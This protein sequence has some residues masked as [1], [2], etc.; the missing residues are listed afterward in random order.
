MKGCDMWWAVGLGIGAAMGGPVGAGIGAVIGGAISECLSGNGNEMDALM[1]A[2]S[3]FLGRFASETGTLGQAEREFIAD[4]CDQISTDRTTAREEIID[5]LPEW[6]ANDELFNGAI[7]AARE[8]E[9]L[10]SQLLSFVWQMASR[11][12]V[13]EANETAWINS[14]SASMGASSE[15]LLVSMIPYQRAEI[16]DEAVAGAREALGVTTT[17]TQHEIKQKYKEL[18][19]KYHPDTHST[20]NETLKELTAVK[21]AQV[22][23][24]YDTLRS[25]SRANFWAVRIESRELFEPDSRSL[26]RCYFCHQKCRLPEPANFENS[27]CPKCRALLL[28]ERELAGAI[29]SNV[30]PPEEKPQPEPKQPEAKP[31]PKQSERSRPAAPPDGQITGDY[32]ASL[33]GCFSRLPRLRCPGSAAGKVANGHRDIRARGQPFGRR[34]VVR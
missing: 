3:C 8:N 11:D 29:F 4:I 32:V 27:R 30:E 26:V 7:N 12:N 1:A 6:T 19:R 13:V 33:H 10:R 14:A 34:S 31:E 18:S 9:V 17:A 23:A 15:E 24:A 5:Q 28:F 22:T 2:V 25:G 21:F 16:D 20:A